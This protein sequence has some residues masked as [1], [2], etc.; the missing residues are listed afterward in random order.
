ME[1]FRAHHQ[2]ANRPH[3]ERFSSLAQLHAACRGYA[4]VAR[5]AKVDWPDLSV[6]H[7]QENLQLVG[8]AGVPAIIS[9][10]AFGQLASRVQAP[11]SYLRTLPTEL[12][13]IN[14]NHGLKHRNTEGHDAVLLLHPGNGNEK[15]VLR[16]VTTDVYERLWNYEVAQRL[17]E[18]AD[19]NNLQPAVPTFSWNGQ[20]ADVDSTALYASDHDMFV[21]LM[22]KERSITNDAADELFRG[23]ICWNSEVG[24]TS[25]GMMRFLFR[26][27]C[28][29]HIIWGAKEVTELRV[30]HVGKIRE[31]WTTFTADVRKYLDSSASDEVAMIKSAKRFTFGATKEDV[32][33]MLF[34]ARQVGLSRKT[35]DAAYEA[36]VPEQDGDPNSAWGFVQGLTRHSQTIPYADR[37]TELDRAGRKVLEFAF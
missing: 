7:D 36:V 2:W 10:H 31:K 8:K 17:Q 5:E 28:M 22:T 21:F 37:R 32:L 4:E 12:A 19:R 18:L 9:H 15:M 6:T 16:A 23:I 35:L 33:D 13:E 30:K 29:N 14:L 26:D 24:G 34:G 1:I 3:D 11:A 27:L 25:L 20:P